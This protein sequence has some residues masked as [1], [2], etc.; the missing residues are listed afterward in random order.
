MEHVFPDGR[1]GKRRLL[2]GKHANV[3]EML[4]RAK[5][6]I[7]FI[8]FSVIVAQ[9]NDFIIGSYQR[10]LNAATVNRFSAKDS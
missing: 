6:F 5:K 4:Q 10:F 2:N 9:N 1:F 7:F 8:H 3:R